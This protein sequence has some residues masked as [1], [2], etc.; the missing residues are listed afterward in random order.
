MD[1][2]K[3][4]CLKCIAEKARNIRHLR[5]DRDRVGACG[6][7]VDDSA[8]KPVKTDQH[9]VL[10]TLPSASTHAQIGKLYAAVVSIS[11]NT[12]INFQLLF[13]NPSKQTMYLDK[14][15]SVP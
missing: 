2:H 8:L 15:S 3:R 9:R 13:S 12:G 7:S 10:A 4:W 11:T 5:C 14:S 1:F 6:L